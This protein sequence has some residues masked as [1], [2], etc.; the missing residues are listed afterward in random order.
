MAAAAAALAFARVQLNQQNPAEVQRT[1]AT[2]TNACTITVFVSEK[3]NTIILFAA[4]TDHFSPTIPA[5]FNVQMFCFF[6]L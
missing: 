2:R 4:D 6:F 3:S 1:S 5:S